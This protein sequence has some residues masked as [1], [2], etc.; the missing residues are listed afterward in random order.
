MRIKYF[1]FK[2]IRKVMNNVIGGLFV[3]S[4]S[5]H[6]L[7]FDHLLYSFRLSF[8]FILEFMIS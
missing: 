2:D 4:F 3:K 6:Y 7:P 5:F 8:E 1:S